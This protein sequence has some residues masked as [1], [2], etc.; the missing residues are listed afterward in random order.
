M[1]AESKYRGLRVVSV[2]GSESNSSTAYS[3]LS[4]ILD[5]VMNFNKKKEISSGKEE[6][7]PSP[8]SSFKES[9]EQSVTPATPSTPLS[10]LSPLSP[11]LNDYINRARRSFPDRFSGADLDK[12]VN[13]KTHRFKEWIA[14]LMVPPPIEKPT[15]TLTS[16]VANLS[17][18]S[19]TGVSVS[20]RDNARMNLSIIHGYPVMDLV[21]VV[22]EVF[23]EE[24]DSNW[25]TASSRPTLT[26]RMHQLLLK[27]LIMRALQAAFAEGVVLIVDNLQWCDLPSAIALTDF[28]SSADYGFGVLCY[29]STIATRENEIQVFSTLR[30]VCY[31]IPLPP[32]KGIEVSELVYHIVSAQHHS[33]VTKEKISRILIRTQGNPGLIEIL[34]IAFRD[35]LNRGLNPN[36]EDIRTPVRFTVYNF[37]M[38]SYHHNHNTALHTCHQRTYAMPQ[39]LVPSCQT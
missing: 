13:P 19:T 18:T 8:L 34:V 24:I 4:N 35:E 20:A 21:H 22:K 33:A 5:Q 14:E 32:L 36:I 25:M 15:S 30:R 7:S 28:I 1:A 38:F 26:P 6:T 11:N 10:P 3:L 17:S 27:T 39:H 37:A 12:L 31:C 2:T 9:T 29:R 16:S 23:Q